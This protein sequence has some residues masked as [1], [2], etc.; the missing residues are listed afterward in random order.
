MPKLSKPTFSQ[1]SRL[2]RLDVS[3]L[4]IG[5]TTHDLRRVDRLHLVHPSGRGHNLPHRAHLVRRITG[6]T[7][8]VAALENVLD[9]ANIKLRTI[10]ELGQFAGIG[11]DV[12]NKVVCEL[13]DRLQ[14]MLALDLLVGE[15]I[16]R[17]R[18]LG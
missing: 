18:P 10:A 3:L 12:I 1:Q 5:L 14:S 17:L 9:V 8:V 11:D 15:E 2:P 6:D 13:K 7:D 4:E 16:L